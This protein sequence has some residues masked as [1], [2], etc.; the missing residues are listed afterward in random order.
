MVF[1]LL[2]RK[3]VLL[4]NVSYKQP[5]PSLLPHCMIRKLYI[6]IMTVELQMSFD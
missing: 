3:L 6:A 4:F 1:L 5:L 2:C